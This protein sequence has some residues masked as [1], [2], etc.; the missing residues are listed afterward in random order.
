MKCLITIATKTYSLVNNIKLAT[1]VA[2]SVLPSICWA[3]STASAPANATATVLASIAITKTR[4]LAFGSGVPG[5]G[6]KLVAA[7]DP[8][9]S[10]S[11]NVTGAASKAY[12]ITLPAGSINMSNGAATIGVSAFTSS[13]ATSGVLSGAG[14]QTITV[15]A[16]RAAL[17]PTQA[18]GSYSGSFTVTV[19]YQ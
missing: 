5:D 4:D 9:A 15:G 19:T 3:G 12:N 10:A 7:S 14:A 8:T 1:I 17:S 2:L 6:A 16:T 11:F 13:P 18:P